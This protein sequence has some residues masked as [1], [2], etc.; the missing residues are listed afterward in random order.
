MRTRILSA[1]LVGALPLAVSAHGSASAGVADPKSAPLVGGTPAIDYVSVRSGGLGSPLRFGHVMPGSEQVQ[2]AGRLLRAGDDYGMDYDTGV[3]YLKRALHDGDSL[4]VSYRYDPSGKSNGGPSFAGV[5][6]FTGFALAP[7]LGLVGGLGLAERAADG[8]VMSSNVYG[9]NGRLSFG[10]SSLSGLYLHSERQRNDTRSG[11]SMDPTAKPGDASTEAGTSQFLLQS[12]RSAILGGKV[13]VDYQDISKN[14]ASGSQV[15]AAGYSDAD[16][17]RLMKERGLKRQGASVDGMRFGGT[18]FSTAFRTVGDA[19]GRGVDWRS[20]GLQQGGLRL[21]LS[22]QKVDPKFSRFADLGE[23]DRDQLAKEGGLSRQRLVGEFAQKVGKL[24]FTSTDVKDDRSG[25]HAIRREARLDGG[26][27]GFD[28]GQQEVDKAFTRVGSLT[29]EEQGQWGR[30]VGARRQWAG[31]SAA[32]GGKTTPVNF[33]FSQ[34]GLKTETGRFDVRDTSYA[35][36]TWSVDHVGMVGKGKAIPT[37]SLQDAEGTAYTKRLA[38][39]FGGAATNDGQRGALL[40]STDVKRDLTRASGNFGKGVG[41]TADQLKFGDGKDK[42]GTAQ[43]VAV[44]TANA[45]ASYRKQELGARFTD[46]SRL[47]DIERARLG[48][49]AGIQRTDVSFG[50][51]IDKARSFAFGQTK[52][53][54]ANGSVDR[55]TY[56]YEAKGLTVNGAQRNVSKGFTNAPN[57]VDPE[58]GLLAQFQG[59]RERDLGVNYA[60]PRMKITA[61]VQDASSEATKEARAVRNADVQW[62]PDKSTSFGYSTQGSSNKDPLTTLFSQSLQRLS[63]THSFGTL[64]T[65]KLQDEQIDNDGKNNAAPDSHKQYVGVETHLTRAT[66]LTT[67]RTRT[68]LSDGNKENV[69][70]NTLSTALSKNIGVSVTKVSIDRQGDDKDERKT[71][72]GV[73]YDLGKGLRVNYGFA[74]SLTGSSAGTGTEMFTFGGTTNTLAPN[75]AGQV[76]ASDVGG[77]MLNGG[78]GAASTMAADPN[79]THTQ[80]FA[81]LGVSTAKPFRFA[82]LTN[83]R[84]TASLDQAADYSQFLREN[85]TAGLSGSYGKNA[86]SFGYRGQLANPNLNPT[87]A[88]V[89]A[90]NVSGIDRSFSLTTDPSARAPIVVNGSVKMR[91]LPEDKDYTSRNFTVTARPVRGVELSN[92]VQTNLE[93]VNPNVLLGSTLLADRGNKWSLGIKPSG[94]TALAA[95]WEEKVNDATDVS[96]TLSALNLTLFQKTNPLKLTYGLDQIDGNL[97]HR[98]VTRYSLQY[99]ARAPGLQTFSLFVGNVGYVYDLSDG[100]RGDNWTVRMNYQI[101]F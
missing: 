5:N 27:I 80:R 91:T 60:G 78:Y 76:G 41:F 101:R 75:Q 8:T 65:L 28:F 10:G 56:A 89:G 45:S 53:Q 18:A 58:S 82:G 14:F 66:S 42:G 40:G 7:G 62:S 34:L 61:F 79:A 87:A 33:A 35:S 36:K 92:Q 49:V 54:D 90:P 71:N 64:V 95:T 12:F 72:Y 29:G 88:T 19:K 11:L 97:A 6:S 93:V 85:Q 15:R 3:V 43:S 73:W 39:F 77:I 26:R 52:A 48:P 81:N 37:T 59:F 4:V 44:K 57:L 67:E 16:V 31:L 20:Y 24:G 30:E 100:F 83:L 1:W 94:D 21:S 69:S 17:A 51:Q 55:T 38:G 23:A 84:V 46:I 99:D 98:Q 96:S 25:K 74:Q 68:D 50:L 47:V 63:M 32:L 70:A 86:F 9:W 2:L 22:S 13:S